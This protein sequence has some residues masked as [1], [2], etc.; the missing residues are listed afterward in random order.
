V[1]DDQVNPYWIAHHPEMKMG[2]VDFLPSQE[3]QFWIDLIDKY[4]FVLKKD[5]Y[6]SIVIQVP[7]VHFPTLKIPKFK[8]LKKF[9]ILE[10]T[11]TN[12]TALSKELRADSIPGK[13]FTFRSR[14]IHVNKKNPK[15][16]S[17]IE[18]A[19]F[20]LVAQ[21]LNQ[22]RHSVPPKKGIRRNKKHAL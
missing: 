3:V 2:D 12:Q 8:G 10:T 20:R 9:K 13:L 16:P 22:L 19:T 15:T 5:V 18:P 14:N 21:C 4:L 1:W 17:M 6:V 7:A 11:L